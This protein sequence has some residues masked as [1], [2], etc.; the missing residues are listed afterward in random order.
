VITTASGRL[1]AIETRKP[2]TIVR[3]VASVWPATAPAIRVVS[4]QITEG[5]GSR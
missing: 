1:T 4:V 5:A 2:M 3:S